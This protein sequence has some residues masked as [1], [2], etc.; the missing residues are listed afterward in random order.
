M[1][2]FFPKFTLFL[3]SW[4]RLWVQ[5]PSTAPDCLGHLSLMKREAAVFT[6]LQIYS[7]TT[8]GILVLKINIFFHNNMSCTNQGTSESCFHFFNKLPK[9]NSFKIK[10]TVICTVYKY[11][12]INC[13]LSLQL[14]KIC[15]WLGVKRNHFH[16]INL[17]NSI[18]EILFLKCDNLAWSS[19]PREYNI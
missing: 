2:S 5:R 6:G 1:A 19:W 17:I 11:L 10:L 4:Y 13:N 12:I 16:A 3:P 8:N 7:K 18:I 9:N 14:L 15:N